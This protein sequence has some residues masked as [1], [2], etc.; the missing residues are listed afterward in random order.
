MDIWSIFLWRISQKQ[1]HSLAH[2]TEVFCDQ[3]LTNVWGNLF[4]SHWDFTC[5]GP[6]SAASKSEG[7]GRKC[8]GCPRLLL[9]FACASWLLI[10]L[11]LLAKLLS[12]KSLNWMCLIWQSKSMLAHCFSP[13]FI[14]NLNH[15]LG[16]VEK[17]PWNLWNYSNL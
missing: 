7:P 4:A 1:Y 5:S 8:L 12:V 16:L 3:M 15:T 14:W 10:A 11:L 2:K 6:E 13:V 17:S 9:F